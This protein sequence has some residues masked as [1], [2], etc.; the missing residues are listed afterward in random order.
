MRRRGVGAAICTN[1]KL[2]IHC[3]LELEQALDGAEALDDALRVV[4][5]VDADAE[6][7]RRRGSPSRSRTAARGTR[8]TGPPVAQRRAAATRSRS[9]SGAPSVRSPRT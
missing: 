4:E 7:V 3:G 2:P 1:V 6:R 5:A 8:A 9:G